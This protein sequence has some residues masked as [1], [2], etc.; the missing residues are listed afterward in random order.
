M[1]QPHPAGPECQKLNDRHKKIGRECQ[2]LYDAYKKTFEDYVTAKVLPF[3]REKNDVNLLQELVKRRSTYKDLTRWLA[4]FFHHLDRYFIGVCKLPTMNATS[5]L[6]FY[7]LIDREREGEQ[8]DQA[9]V[10]SVL[11]IYVE[12]GEGSTKEYYGKDF[13]EAMLKDLF[14]PREPQS[15]LPAFL[16]KITCLRSS[17]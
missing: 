5:F 3:L 16:T 4:R 14:I 1:C 2:K 11:D 8:I 9:L 15:G 17:F 6:T 7:E 12:I 10:K 13:E